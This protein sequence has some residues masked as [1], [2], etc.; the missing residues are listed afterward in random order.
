MSVASVSTP[1]LVGWVALGLV[2]GLL[3]GLLLGQALGRSTRTPDER[4]RASRPVPGSGRPDGSH[5]RADSP[6]PPARRV[7]EVDD[8][9]AFLEHPPGSPAPEAPR[10]TTS[11]TAPAHGATAMRM[12]ATDTTAMGATAGRATSPTGSGRPSAEALSAGRTVL[13]MVTAAAVLV[14][15]AV[16]IALVS[17]GGPAGDDPAGSAPA[18]TEP[19]SEP[20]TDEPDTPVAAVRDVPAGALAALSVPLGEEGMT[21]RATFATILLEERAVGVTVTRPALSVSTDGERALAHLRLPTFNCLTRLPPADPDTAGCARA[22]TEFADLTAPGLRMS[23]DGDRLELTGRFPTY[24][25][26]PGRAPA[27]TG[28]SYRLTASLAADGPIRDGRA[29]A[30]GVLQLGGASATTTGVPGLDVLQ[31]RG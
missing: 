6:G 7:L 21:A 14:A 9:P 28:R 10:A 22:A 18:A 11:A 5:G 29:P 25:R 19:V 20:T 16:L 31:L 2:L 8:L 24:T 15:V 26:P 17:R 12:T 4:D 3:G 1:A 27:Y 13:A 23:R 30:T